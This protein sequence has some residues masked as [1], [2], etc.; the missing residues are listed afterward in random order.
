MNQKE[1]EMILE[2]SKKETKQTKKTDDMYIELLNEIEVS[3][4]QSGPVLTRKLTPQ[5]NRKEK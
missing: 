1:N 3:Q 5:K 2:S 4:K